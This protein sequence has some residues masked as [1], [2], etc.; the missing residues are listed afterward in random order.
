M[1]K[2]IKNIIEGIVAL[3]LGMLIGVAYLFKYCPFNINTPNGMALLNAW[4]MFGWAFA[5]IICLY[6]ICKIYLD[7]TPKKSSR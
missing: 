6:G 3:F 2:N 4:S 7:E 5:A 1:K